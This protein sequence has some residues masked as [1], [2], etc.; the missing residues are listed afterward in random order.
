M[1]KNMTK[2][3]LTVLLL[4]V[5]VLGL[6]ACGMIDNS[7]SSEDSQ[8]TSEVESNKEDIPKGSISLELPEGF[9]ASEHY[10]NRQSLFESMPLSKDTVVFI[11]D[12]IVQRNEWAESF[13]S[14]NYINRGI[15]NDTISGVLGRINSIVQYN[16]KQIFLMVGINDIYQNTGDQ[17]ELINQYQQ[18]IDKVKETAPE[19]VITVTSILP[20]NKSVYNHMADNN[21]IIEFNEKLKEFCETNDITYVDTFS[22][23]YDQ[24]N[25][26]MPANYTNDGI[27]LNGDG[28]KVLDE[29]LKEYI[30]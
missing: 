28:Y 20:V 1:K 15:D 22:E 14:T 19:T 25:N 3:I 18:L 12:S 11:G 8:S 16:P 7:N 27:H 10:L 17:E 26:E 24:E 4:M 9:N 29:K 5:T 2:A 30:Q 23:F 6:A 21:I 13:G